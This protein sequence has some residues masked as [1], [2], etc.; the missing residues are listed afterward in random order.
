MSEVGILGTT[1]SIGQ[2]SVT[3]TKLFPTTRVSCHLPSPGPLHENGSAAFCHVGSPS[4]VSV[5]RG[6]KR[7]RGL[8]SNTKGGNT[9]GPPKSSCAR[10][11]LSGREGSPRKPS[12]KPE[13]QRSQ[14]IKRKQES[15]KVAQQAEH[16]PRMHKTMGSIPSTSSNWVCNQGVEAGGSRVPGQPVLPR[17]TLA[18]SPTK[19]R[20]RIGV[21]WCGKVPLD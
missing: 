16:V 9:P 15:W 2:R 6:K 20:I 11:A 12:S 8:K 7:E 5:P 18:Q 1:Q 13:I 14:A 21:C 10:D 3:H 4:C 19:L 17:K